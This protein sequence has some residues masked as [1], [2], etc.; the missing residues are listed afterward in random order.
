MS[1]HGLLI[2]LVDDFIFTLEVVLAIPMILTLI[3]LITCAD[4]TR[5]ATVLVLQSNRIQQ[6]IYLIE[7]HLGHCTL[8]EN[9]LEFIG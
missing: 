7:G 6:S 4:S 5:L 9:A 8:V 1:V 2:E 3:A